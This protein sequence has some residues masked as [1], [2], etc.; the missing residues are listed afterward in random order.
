MDLY[1]RKV[2]NQVGADRQLK[3]PLSSSMERTPYLIEKISGRQV[4]PQLGFGGT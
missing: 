3:V 1:A 4:R 2:R